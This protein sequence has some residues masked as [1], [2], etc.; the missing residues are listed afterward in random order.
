MS[1]KKSG[2]ND[3]GYDVTLT[4]TGARN[5]HFMEV[6]GRRIGVTNGQD[7]IIVGD[8]VSVE[9]DGYSHITPG[10]KSNGVGR[11]CGI[12]DD[13]TDYWFRVN[14]ISPVVGSGSVKRSCI[15][16]HSANLKSLLP[17]SK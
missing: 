7:E 13:D 4:A 10:V 6:S 11:V 3:L 2:K 15:A 12:A 9:A 16:A 8:Y 14:M 17:K 5:F 1:S